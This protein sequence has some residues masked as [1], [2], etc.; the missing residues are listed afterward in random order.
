MFNHTVHAP[1]PKIR[2]MWGMV[3]VGAR[4]AVATTVGQPHIIPRFKQHECQVGR[5]AG[6]AHP[7]AGTHAQPMPKESDGA[8]G[9]GMWVAQAQQPQNVPIFHVNLVGGGIISMGT[10]KV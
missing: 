10:D 7:N 4:I 1:R 9:R 5:S 8:R 3:G 6:V 2:F